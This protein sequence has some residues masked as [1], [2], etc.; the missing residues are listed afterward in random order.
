MQINYRCAT[1]TFCTFFGPIWDSISPFVTC[2]F[3]GVGELSDARVERV[4]AYPALGAGWADVP[5]VS[6]AKAALR[7]SC[8]IANQA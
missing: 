5:V 4:G 1:M 8:S 6:S 3:A 2:F 7:L